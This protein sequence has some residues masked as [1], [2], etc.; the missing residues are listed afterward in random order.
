MTTVPTEGRNTRRKERTRAALVRAAQELLANGHAQE[1]SIKAI[2]ELA[3]V[4]FGSFFNHFE[5]KAALFDTALIEAARRYEDWLDSQ[6]SDVSDPLQRL[7]L[8]IRLTGRLHLTHPDEAKLLIGQMSFLHAGKPALAD[9]VR[10]D[11]VAAIASLHPEEVSSPSTV[12]AATGAIG[13]V[14]GAAATLPVEDRAAL[15]DALVVDVLRML[16]VQVTHPREP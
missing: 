6:L 11:I 5:N 7:A 13:A 10:G 9:R 15:A 3:D 8:S 16:G 4:G 14:L 1:A 2:T 12:I